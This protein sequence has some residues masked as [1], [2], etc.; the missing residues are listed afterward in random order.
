MCRLGHRVLVDCARGWV[1]GLRD[2][3]QDELAEG[4]DELGRLE[5]DGAPR[6]HGADE[7]V[8]GQ[9]ER[10]VPRAAGEVRGWSAGRLVSKWES[11][12]VVRDGLG[13]ILGRWD[14]SGDKR[15]GA[16]CYRVPSRT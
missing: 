13:T 7:W 5:H 9:H 16:Q 4:R 12:Q 10:V 15:V 3:A 2:E 14:A 11:G 8:H 1:E 6:G